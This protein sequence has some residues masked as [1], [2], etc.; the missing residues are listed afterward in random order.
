MVLSKLPFINRIVSCQQRLHC[1]DEGEVGTTAVQHVVCMNCANIAHAQRRARQ[2]N[3]LHPADQPP[4]QVDETRSR[5]K[6]RAIAGAF[7][8]VAGAISGHDEFQHARFLH[9]STFLAPHSDVCDLPVRATCLIQQDVPIEN[10]N[11]LKL[12]KRFSHA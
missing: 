10:S 5:P 6:Q 9:P 3:L 4:R 7:S 2:S 1:I 12:T 11:W 8:E